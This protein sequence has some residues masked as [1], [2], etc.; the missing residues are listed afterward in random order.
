MGLDKALDIGKVDRQSS[1]PYIYKKKS[2]QGS[3]LQGFG[4][5]TL[6]PWI[7]KQALV[8]CTHYKIGPKKKKMMATIQMK[9]KMV[10]CNGHKMVL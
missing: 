1:K 5:L 3:K 10:G 9:M 2:Y 6:G 7:I 4:H 8:P